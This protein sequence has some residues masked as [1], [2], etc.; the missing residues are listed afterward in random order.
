[1]ASSSD[2]KTVSLLSMETPPKAKDAPGAEISHRLFETQ[3]KRAG[4]GKRRTSVMKCDRELLSDDYPDSLSQKNYLVL[5][6][7][8]FQAKTFK[9]Q[10]P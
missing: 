9:T 1:M 5:R 8:M 6:I 4:Q 3:A 10:H 7:Q 2:F